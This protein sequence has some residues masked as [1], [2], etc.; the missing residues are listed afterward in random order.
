MRVGWSRRV[1]RKEKGTVAIIVLHLLTTT[2]T[3]IIVGR[4]GVFQFSLLLLLLLL[5]LVLEYLLPVMFKD[6]GLVLESVRKFL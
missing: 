5:V 4:V 2:T 6:L 1:L 3:I